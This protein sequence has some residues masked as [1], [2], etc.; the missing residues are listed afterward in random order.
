MVSNP[1]EP[2]GKI[3]SEG[4]HRCVALAAFLA[5]LSTLDTPS[6]IVFDD[7]VSSLDH[8]HRDKVAERL[9]IEGLN[10]QVVIFTHDIAFLVLLEEACRKTRDRA[11]IP[12]AYRVVSRGRDAAG[13]CN[14]EPPANVLAVEKVI[15]Q[16]RNHLANVKTHHER[17]DQASWRREVGSFERGLREA[18]ERAVENAVSPVIKRLARKVNTDG[19][20]QLTIFQEQDC[21]VM[22]DSYGRCSQWLHSQPGEFNPSL[23]TPSDIEKEITALETWIQSIRDRQNK[24]I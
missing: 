6:G 11:A 5:E 21:H 7:P 19:L 17:G 8:I 23:P 24:H 18:W 10:R 13:F 14:A 12:L 3:L 2:V 4:E 22:R 15:Q 20:I 16:M 1:D 9:A